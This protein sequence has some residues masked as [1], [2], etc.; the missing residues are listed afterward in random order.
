MTS[1]GQ[2]ASTPDKERRIGAALAVSAKIANSKFGRFRPP[3]HILDTNCGSG[4]NKAAD[5]PGS[6]IVAHV[7]ADQHLPQ[8]RPHLF[9]CDISS[10][11]IKRLRVRLQAEPHHLART[12][13]FEG[14]N[15]EAVRLFAGGINRMERNPQHA[16]GA[17]IVDPNGYWYRSREG[18]G[19]PINTL[20]RFCQRYPKIDL[21][22]N[23]NMRWFRMARAHP[24]GTVVEDPITLLL[25]MKSHWLV[26]RPG[27]GSTSFLIAVGRNIP[28]REHRALGFHALS[29]DEG[30]SIVA[31]ACGGRQTRLA[32]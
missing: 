30:K 19:A 14:D 12:F 2:G 18:L 31:A 5:C 13:L 8:M 23:L 15:E 27:N 28:T 6:P 21:I 9:A 1:Q 16:V 20:P 24:W 26:S 32:V 22:L 17:I 25:R 29:S 3:F 4:W 10:D 7:I 11:M